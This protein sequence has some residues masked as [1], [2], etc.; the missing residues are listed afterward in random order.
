MHTV[1]RFLLLKYILEDED[2]SS[3][4]AGAVSGR[5]GFLLMRKVCR[6]WAGRSRA[7]V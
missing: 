5:R 2:L 7:K 6:K 1:T 4:F 3:G